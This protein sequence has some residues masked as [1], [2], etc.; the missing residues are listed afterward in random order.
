MY[1][2][3][4]NIKKERIKNII[5]ISII[6]FVAIFS[7]Y[8]IY[9]KF[10]DTENI[11]YSSDSLDVTFHEKDGEQLDITKVT[12]L[13]DSVGLSSKG[14]TI[15][16]TNNLTES[17]N[18]KIKIVDNKEK[19]EEQNCEGI[20]IPREEI[21]VSIKETGQSTKV[22]KLS[23][24]ERGILLSKTANALET[25]KY[26][27]RIWVSND[28]TLPSGS[29]NHYHGIIQIFENDTTLAVK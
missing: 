28:T 8:N 13:T 24:L 23:E 1:Y 5:I 7:T 18:Y 16:I 12:P 27:I 22:Y 21:K 10:S 29:D 14:H 20:T 3:N 26:T 2:T 6:L 15:K 4:Y 11:D 9:Q 25:T 17:V 19:M